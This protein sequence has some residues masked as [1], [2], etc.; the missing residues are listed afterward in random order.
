VQVKFGKLYECG[1]KWERKLFSVSSWRFFSEKVLTALTE[2]PD[3]YLAY[4]LSPDDGFKGDMFIFPVAVFAHAVRQADRVS[5]GD[6]R[7]FIS[8]SKQE[9]NR[10]YVRRKWAFDALTPETAFE[11]TEHYRNFRCLEAR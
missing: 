6:Y 1:S 9:P 3:V 4:V 5:K 8:R 7:V 11:V 2:R 10:W